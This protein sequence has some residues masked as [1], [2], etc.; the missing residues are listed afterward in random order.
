M[1]TTKLKNIF[2]VSKKKLLLLITI[3][4]TFRTDDGVGIHVAR[5]IEKLPANVAILNAEDRPENIISEAIRLKP[6]KTVIIDAADFKGTPGEIKVIKKN[7]VPSTSLSTHSISPLVLAAIIEEETG[8]D[9]LFLGIQPQSI[10]MGE[11][12]TPPVKKAAQKII[13][14][15]HKL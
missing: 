1:L 12:L 10:Q 7:N 3:G 8:S 4:N 14:C 11:G 5:H 2:N 15:I 6:V 9:V 13:S